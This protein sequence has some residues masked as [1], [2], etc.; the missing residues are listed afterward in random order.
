MRLCRKCKKE[1]ILARSNRLYCGPDCQRW[2]YWNRK[3]EKLARVMKGGV[4]PPLQDDYKLIK[5][6]RYIDA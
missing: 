2:S 3:V 1:M 6:A 5:D 4:T